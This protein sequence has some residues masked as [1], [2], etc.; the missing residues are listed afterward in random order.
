LETYEIKWTNRATKDLRKIYN[1]NIGI[2][3]EEGAFGLVLLLLERVDMLSDKRFV[4]M[5]AVDE[6]FRY[7]KR[8]YKKLIE[9]DIKI[10][11]RISTTKPVVYI[12]RVFDT[13]QNPRKN[14]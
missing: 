4:K 13:R 10:T 9:G 5:G 2:I 12:N 6:E 14:R 1:F 7:L 3:G 11:Y 8:G